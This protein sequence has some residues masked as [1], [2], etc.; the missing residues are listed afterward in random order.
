MDTRIPECIRPILADY[1]LSLRTEL[2]DLIDAC[3]IH[4]SI[5]LGAFNPHLSDIDFITILTRRATAQ[6]V[7]NLKAVHQELELIYP[8]WKL[9][10]SYLQWE[11]LG[12]SQQEIAPYPYYHDRV[13]RSAGYHD[14]NLVTWW[15]LKHR[16]ISIIG[17][18]SQMLA[19]AVDWNLLQI[20][21]KEN[22]NSYWVSWTRSPSKVAYLLTDSGIQWAVL[23]VVRL[24]YTL[25]EHD[26][27]SKTEAGRYA[28]VH[29]P[30]KWHQLIQEAIN[31][32]EIRHGSSYRSKVSRA[33]EAVRFLR[34]VINV[35]NEQ[36]S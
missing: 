13:L 20:K 3:Y 19:F 35:C 5:A 34:Y 6:E 17:L 2:P 31:L 24:F 21:M 30:A 27:T 18:P 25:R 23:G 36:A 32:R 12:R 9:E 10:G 16:G 14:V 29:L 1:L 11:D 33:V 4:G 7:E 15:V 28:L 26:I 8:Q 22:L